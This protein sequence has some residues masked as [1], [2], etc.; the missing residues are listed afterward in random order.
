MSLNHGLR[1]FKKGILP[2]EFNSSF[3]I[4]E[5]NIVNDYLKHLR[6]NHIKSLF[7][8]KD[9]VRK[10]FVYVKDKSTNKVLTA[11]YISEIKHSA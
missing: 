8:K 7:V 9:E 5:K 1:I 11:F 6:F 4:E 3:N 2:I 10:N